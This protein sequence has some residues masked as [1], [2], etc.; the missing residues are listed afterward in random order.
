MLQALLSSVATAFCVT[1]PTSPTKIVTDIG[2]VV[3]EIP[4]KD[5]N[6][7]EA[8]PALIHLPYIT[9]AVSMRKC[10]HANT[11]VRSSKRRRLITV[12]LAATVVVEEKAVLDVINAAESSRL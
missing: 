8:S 10:R 5:V 2:S 11:I 6:V 12:M 4:I 3:P 9:I 1:R 7:A